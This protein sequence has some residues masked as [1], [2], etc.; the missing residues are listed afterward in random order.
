MLASSA[1][2]FAACSGELQPGPIGQPLEMRQYLPDSLRSEAAAKPDSTFRQTI[3]VG[4]DSARVEIEW[5]TFRHATGRYVS[6]VSARLTKS[7]KLDS[8][9][10]GNVSALKNSGT[11]TDPIESGNV[12]VLWYMHRITGRQSG[13]MNFGFDAVG[14]RTI[15][16]A[17]R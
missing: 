7:T 9:R 17:E 4:P 13:A 8:L 12:Q 10:L 14:R 6:S 16:P 15:G 3:P 11:K 2:V 1:V 5:A